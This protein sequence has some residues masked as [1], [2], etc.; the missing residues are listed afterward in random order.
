MGNSSTQDNRVD[1]DSSTSN[2]TKLN[3]KV[4][5][6]MWKTADSLR[7]NTVELALL[8]MAGDEE[9]IAVTE[10]WRF[11]TSRATRLVVL[12][13]DDPSFSNVTTFG[14]TG[15]TYKRKGLAAK[16]VQ[17]SFDEV[18]AKLDTA[19]SSFRLDSEESCECL[20]T[21]IE[22]YCQRFTHGL[23]QWSIQ[24]A[25]WEEDLVNDLT[26]HV[27]EKTKASKFDGRGR[28]SGWVSTVCFNFCTDSLKAFSKERDEFDGLITGE[29]S[30]AEEHRP[31]KGRSWGR[32]SSGDERFTLERSE[33]RLQGTMEN[34]I[35]A[36]E[37]P[38]D[39][40]YA[41]FMELGLNQKQAALEMCE[42]VVTARKREQRVRAALQEAGFGVTAPGVTA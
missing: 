11:Q 6:T 7:P 34:V 21:A 31:K 3:I 39:R 26:A 17:E 37:N 38:A 14:D 30:E 9:A 36:L 13:F 10:A 35:E 28:Y 27:F 23:R 32:Q 18:K 16:R 25:G 15:G 22:T 1:V 33:A 29:Q 24:R 41:R 40:A 19:F 4:T 20:W 5:S 2:S 8:C 12:P 42:S